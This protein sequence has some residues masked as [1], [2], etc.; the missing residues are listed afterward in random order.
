M[1][2]SSS[3]VMPTPT[4]QLLTKKTASPAEA[5]PPQITACI[6]P[7][8]ADWKI[9]WLPVADLVENRQIGHRNSL[10]GVI[11]TGEHAQDKPG[12]A[13]EITHLI[14]DL[15]SRT[16]IG[17]DFSGIANMDSS[18]WQALGPGLVEHTLSG[19]LGAD[20]R[21]LY[22]IDEN[23]WL[24][25]D[26]Q[27]AFEGVARARFQAQPAGPHPNLA[28][29]AP[30]IEEGFCGVLA[31]L[32]AEALNLVNH[33]GSLNSLELYH[34]L[35]RRYRLAPAH[36]DQ[37]M[38]LLAHLGL[39]HR[40]SA[41]RSDGVITYDLNAKGYSLSIPEKTIREKGYRLG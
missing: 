27:C 28:A 13:R 29:L 16:L 9:A 20:K 7:H 17:L 5:S 26:L 11:V 30:G 40:H 36:A 35:Q 32:Y 19:K 31:P 10:V 41:A 1:Y 39:L 4:T 23:N 14:K 22:M 34:H 37:C 8:L 38:A 24:A 18:L 15:P 12:L 21:L 2:T 3:F 6:H 25:T 33:Y